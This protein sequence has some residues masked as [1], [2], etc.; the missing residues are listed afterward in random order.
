MLAFSLGLLLSASLSQA[1]NVYLSPSNYFPS[2]LSPADASAA[3]SRHLGLEQFEPL[4]DASN[5]GHEEWFVG[6]GSKNALLI[7]LEETD[8][9][10]VVPDSLRVSFTLT[11]PLLMSLSSATSTYL[12]RARHMFASV[13]SS[14][15][16]GQLEDIQSFFDSV[17][18]P[19][20]ASMDLSTLHDIRET[21]GSSS[22]EYM[23]VADKLRAYLDQMLNDD[24]TNLAIVTL[25]LPSAQSLFKRQTPQQSQSP[26]PQQPIG[27]ISGCFTTLDACDNSTSSCSGRGTCVQA[28]KAGRTCFVCNCGV[29]KT[30]EGNQVKTVTWVGQSC[31][32][33][34]ISGPFVLLSGTVI[35]II[36]L[37]I[38]SVSLLYSVGEQPL[39]STLLATA[40]NIK[41][42]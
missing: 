10:A 26:S 25:P 39:P 29:T 13:Y 20:F 17:E 32:R 7:T 1:V 30:G 37:F 21:Y 41:K 19:A 28:S 2:P 40:V 3:L 4:L 22:D 8:L 6:Q 9:Q 12:H 11:T 23:Q 42:D 38:G 18:S 24:N 33:Q 31:E 5:L 27:S 15:D 35:V 34:D 16:F 36:V 14:H